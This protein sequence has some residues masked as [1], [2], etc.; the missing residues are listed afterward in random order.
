MG[1][2]VKKKN[3]FTVV[4]GG[5][6]RKR[7]CLIHP[8][9]L[10]RCCSLCYLG[11]VATCPFVWMSALESRSSVN[12]T[13]AVAPGSPFQ[14]H[15]FWTP[16]I[17]QPLPHPWKLFYKCLRDGSPTGLFVCLFFRSLCWSDLFGFLKEFFKISYMQ[18]ALFLIIQISYDFI[19]KL[20][21]Y[22]PFMR[23]GVEL[24]VVASAQSDIWSNPEV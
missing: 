2:S 14:G 15:S 6:V 9:Y 18:T 10:L 19:I 1:L 12:H 17:L 4:L 23:F 3:L 24:G 16:S 8:L 22:L 21:I 7:C 13:H 5:R 11:S 20:Y